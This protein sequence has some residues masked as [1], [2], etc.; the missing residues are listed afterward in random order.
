MMTPSFERSYGRPSLKETEEEKTKRNAAIHVA[1][2]NAARVPLR[3]AKDAVKVME[4]ALKCAKEANLNAVSD[5]ISACHVTQ[6]S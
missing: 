2:F 1:S 3:V 4:L 6:D 5:P